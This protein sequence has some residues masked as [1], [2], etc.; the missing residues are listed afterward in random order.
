VKTYPYYGLNDD[1]RM[2]AVRYDPKDFRQRRPMPDGNW[3]WAVTAGEYYQRGGR[4]DWYKLDGKEKESD[5]RITMKAVDLVLWNLRAVVQAKSENRRIWVVEGEKDA[6]TVIGAGLCATTNPMGALK[7]REEYTQSLRGAHVV[8]LPD[9]D[10]KGREH[11]MHVYAA[12]NG[13]AASIRYLEPPGGC[14][15][16]T[17]YRDKTQASPERLRLVLEKLLEVAPHRPP[18]A[19]GPLTPETDEYS[20]EVISDSDLRKMVFIPPRQVIPGI[21]HSG[22]TILAGG[23]KVGK[24]FFCL[25]A[26]QAVAHGGA[27]FGSVRCDAGEALGLFLEDGG[28]RIQ[29]RLRRLD[30]ADP[31]GDLSTDKLHYVFD[32]PPAV[33]KDRRLFADRVLRP[34]TERMPNLSLVIVDT[35]TKIR[36]RAGGKNQNLYEVDYDAIEPFQML[37]KERQVAVVFVHHTRKQLSEDP[38]EE[39]S[40]TLGLTGSADSVLVL[41]R[42]RFERRGVLSIISRDIGEAALSV[43]Y[44]ESTNVWS[45]V[46]PADQLAIEEEQQEILGILAERHQGMEPHQIGREIGKTA[47]GA[48][49]VLK[50]M[51]DLGLV[52][53]DGARF[54]AAVPCGRK[55]AQERLSDHLKECLLHRNGDMSCPVCANLFAAAMAES[56]QRDGRMAAAGEQ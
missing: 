27:A 51:V 4:G 48:R 22:V 53:Q 15:D 52:T 16:I 50:R 41:K 9:I 8:L 54:R 42:K 33:K 11:A 35:L 31:R 30:Q 39:V 45:I 34:L 14:K 1:L 47:S 56:Q 13:A 29:S 19:A 25:Q 5:P 44:D 36:P 2:E 3:G 23:P 21:V 46:G 20:V 32:L 17:E 55:T 7:W 28:G 24:S 40:G 43:D 12:L 26:A 37:A 6:E 38:L 10:S 18:T 49:K